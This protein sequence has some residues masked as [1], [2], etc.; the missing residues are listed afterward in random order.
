[1]PQI[2]VLKWEGEARHH[3]PSLSQRNNVTSPPSLFYGK[4]LTPTI[5][6]DLMEN[7]KLEVLI[8]KDTDINVATV[9]RS[10][11][12][13]DYADPAS[14]IEQRSLLYFGIYCIAT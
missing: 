4:Q 9:L 8:P 1:M 14:S 7:S 3:A 5:T 10:S 12:G 2:T 13:I 11:D 6:N